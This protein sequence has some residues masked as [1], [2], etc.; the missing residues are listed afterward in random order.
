MGTYI[1]LLMAVLRGL[2]VSRGD[3]V[4]E[5]LALKHQLAMCGRRPRVRGGDRLLWVTLFRCWTGWRSALVVLN[6][7]TVVRWH[8]EGWR[9]YWRW[10]SRQ[11]RG[12]RRKIAPEARELIARIA[13][14]NPRW[15]AVR[16]RGELLALGHDV[17]AASVRRYRRQA[18]RRPPSQRWHTFIT[19]HRHDLWA[20]DFFTVPTLLFQTLYVFVVVSHDRRRIEHINV[21]A[22]PTAAWVWQ[23]MIESTPWGR[24]PGVLLRDRDRCYGADFIARAARIG[25]ETVLTPIHTPQANGVVERLIGTLR[26]ECVAHIIPLNERHLRQVMREYVVYYNDTRP[27]RTLALEPPEGARIPQRN[28]PVIAIPI[29]GGLHHRYERK[30]A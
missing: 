15:G 24:K 29:L 12:G 7:D 22:H 3:L 8:R 17:S 26:R 10:K 6:P 14:E 2:L 1:G 9:R 21:T 5:N 13:R 30:A 25:I 16:I 19:N 4:L 18:L 27:H 11:K 28:G 20:V 23:Q